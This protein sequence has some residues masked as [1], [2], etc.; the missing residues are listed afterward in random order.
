MGS[1]ASDDNACTE[2]DEVDDIDDRV[3][4][5]SCTALKYS[6]WICASVGRVTT[7]R[8]DDIDDLRLGGGAYVVLMLDGEVHILSSASWIWVVDMCAGAASDVMVSGAR[9]TIRGVTG[10][11]WPYD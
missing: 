6:G 4:V 10:A 3:R 11:A 7:E 8:A 2:L 5:R 1:C 9:G